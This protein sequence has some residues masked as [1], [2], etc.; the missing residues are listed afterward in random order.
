MKELQT[1]AADQLKTRYDIR[2]VLKTKVHLGKFKLQPG[3]K[4]YEMVCTSNGG[5]SVPGLNP[6]TGD[7]DP[8][9]SIVREASWDQSVI[10]AGTPVVNGLGAVLP[11]VKR[12]YTVQDGNIYEVA[13]NEANAR[14]KIIAKYFPKP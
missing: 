13:I 14:R 10:V 8:D 5:K 12:K 2:Q 1:A 4:L 11:S 9:L 6:V 3:Q 7:F